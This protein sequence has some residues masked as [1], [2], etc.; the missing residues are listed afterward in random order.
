MRLPK[1]PPPT[2]R[3]KDPPSHH[4]SSPSVTMAPSTYRV[5]RVEQRSRR[6]ETPPAYASASTAPRSPFQSSGSRSR[7]AAEQTTSSTVLSSPSQTRGGRGGQSRLAAEQVAS[8]T[9]PGS[10][11]HG[12]YRRQLRP[13]ITLNIQ[14]TVVYVVPDTP[15]PP[16]SPPASRS[17]SPEPDSPTPAPST[18]ASSINPS[19]W[20]SRQRVDP[21]D[22]PNIGLKKF[23][24]VSTGRVCGVFPNWS[25]ASES[26][27]GL[28]ACGA[29]WEGFHTWATAWDLYR[30]KKRLGSVKVIGRTDGD[31]ATFGPIEEAIQ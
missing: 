23:Q 25:T 28:E 2:S 18:A 3:S 24:V 4:G 10:P 14:P 27:R 9:P 5:H 8:S 13:L 11:R 30:R 26:V 12:R 22:V 20:L 17:P 6:S 7:L 29:V 21:E 15:S 1:T 16:E 31:V 19:D